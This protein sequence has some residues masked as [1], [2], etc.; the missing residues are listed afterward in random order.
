VKPWREDRLVGVTSGIE[1][2]HVCV[3]SE[4]AVVRNAQYR[5]SSTEKGWNV[6]LMLFLP[7]VRCAAPWLRTGGRR[8]AQAHRESSMPQFVVVER[9]ALTPV[10]AE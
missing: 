7:I 10:P 9:S 5:V 3:S 4:T 1:G 6:V 8:Q 2:R